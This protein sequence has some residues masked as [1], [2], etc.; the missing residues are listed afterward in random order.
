MRVSVGA[1]IALI[2]FSFSLHAALKERVRDQI[3]VEA[4]LLVNGKVVSSPRIVTVA[5]ERAEI[6]QRG[7]K[8]QI[9]M[10]VTPTPS[11]SKMDEIVLDMD[12]KFVSGE[13]VIHSSPQVYVK[14][15]VDA[16]MTLEESSATEKIQLKVMAR[17]V[18]R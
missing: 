2:G 14:A 15:G 4:Q 16:V 10:G 3:R 8:D 12:I 13:R 6:S 11:N 7:L 5:G 17:P 1:A 18:V 9:R